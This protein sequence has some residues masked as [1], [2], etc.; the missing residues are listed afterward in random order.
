MMRKIKPNKASSPAVYYLNQ[1]QQKLNLNKET[2]ILYL[3]LFSQNFTTDEI[4]EL[5][6]EERYI[7]KQTVIERLVIQELAES[8]KDKDSRRFVLNM[9]SKVALAPKSP[10]ENVLSNRGKD[11]NS[12]CGKT[13]LDTLVDEALEGEIT[14]EKVSLDDQKKFR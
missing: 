8:T 14:S 13:L 3:S 5:N 6:T 10:V 7:K 1:N 12:S 11:E 4:E 2:A 9:M